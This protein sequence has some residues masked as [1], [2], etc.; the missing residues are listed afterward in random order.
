MLDRLISIAPMLDWTDRH[1]R[2]FLRLLSRRVLLYTGMVTTGAMLHGDPQRFLAYDPVEHPLALQLGGSNPDE[3]A[4]CAR[5]AAD[6]GYDEVNLN[7]GC[8]SDRVQ[9][10]RFGA[11]LMAESALVSDCVAA[12]RLAADLPVTIKTRIGI[13]ERDSYEE[14]TDFVGRVAMGGCQ[15]FII[16]AR[17]AWLRGLSPKENREIPPLHYEVVHRLKRDFPSL[18]VVLNGGLTTLDQ[19]AKQLQEVDGVMIGRAAYEN[20][21]WLTEVDSRFF[22]LRTSPPSRHQV[23]EA[24]L[25]YIEDQLRRGTPLHCMTRHILGLFQGVPGARAWRR[26]LSEQACQRGAGKGVVEAALGQV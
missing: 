25:P 18:T 20:P 5:I 12:M 11:C 14:L 15:V 3:L 16:H 2:F 6:W 17:K 19:I 4:Q 8:P 13:D 24:F 9:S 7:I 26:T 22:G 10:G 21:Y 1:C 23:V